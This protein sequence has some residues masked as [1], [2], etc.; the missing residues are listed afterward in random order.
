MHRIGP[1]LTRTTRP[2][3]K[4]EGQH[5]VLTLC[6]YWTPAPPSNVEGGKLYV[7]NK[8]TTG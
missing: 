7:K 5:S 3:I 4:T 8:P 2:I 6:L 1:I